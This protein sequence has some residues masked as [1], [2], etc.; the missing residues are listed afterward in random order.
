MLFGTR[1]SK[2]SALVGQYFIK[3][4]EY[5][6]GIPVS[7]SG[8]LTCWADEGVLLLNTVLT[9]RESKP[10]SHAGIGWERFTDSVI[11]MISD[12]PYPTVFM[13]WGNPAKS[14]RKTYR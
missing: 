14:K 7:D 8:N 6:L 5:D 13:L 4:L 10:Q 2:V 3:A 12:S 1:R 11:K 9:V